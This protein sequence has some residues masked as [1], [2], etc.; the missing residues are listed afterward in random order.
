MRE[1]LFKRVMDTYGLNEKR[2]KE[3]E[4][5]FPLDFT[6]PEFNVCHLILD[7]VQKKYFYKELRGKFRSIG[8]AQDTKNTIDIDF[9][10]E[11]KLSVREQELIDEIKSKIGELSEQVYRS[12]CK[13]AQR[14]RLEM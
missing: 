9:Y 6:E 8:E 1:N 7:E 12:S 13:K 5:V 10:D 4:V 2:K 11:E 3:L 14:I